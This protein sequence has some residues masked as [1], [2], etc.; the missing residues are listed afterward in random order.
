MQLYS[1]ANLRNTPHILKESKHDDDI[2]NWFIKEK[3]YH[4]LC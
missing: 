1:T 4:F 3:K 2:F